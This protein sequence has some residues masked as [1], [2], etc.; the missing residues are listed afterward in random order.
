LLLD[1]LYNANVLKNFFK[2]YRKVILN[3]DAQT[4]CK[5]HIARHAKSTFKYVYKYII[6]K[7]KVN[8]EIR[9]KP[10]RI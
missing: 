6:I 8:I 10:C 1:Y 2:M 9:A 7:F 5:E 4:R 3:Y